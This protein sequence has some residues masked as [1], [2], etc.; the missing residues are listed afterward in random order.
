VWLIQLFLVVL[1]VL[2]IIVIII[3]FLSMQLLS[4]LLSHDSKLFSTTERL[5]LFFF[6]RASIITGKTF[7]NVGL[8]CGLSELA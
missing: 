6:F 4:K 7:L 3:V 2:V 8:S 1:V 5:N